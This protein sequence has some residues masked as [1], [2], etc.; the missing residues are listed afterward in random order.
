MRAHIDLYLTQVK[1]ALASMF[2]YRISNLLWLV[3]MVV[4]PVVYLVV[5][6]SV[7]RQ[8][9]GSVAGYTPGGFAAYYITW[10]LVRQMNIALTPY[11]FESRVRKGELSPMLLRPMHPF[12]FDLAWFMGFK[13]VTFVLWL[14]IA[15]VLTLAF[16]PTLDPTWWQVAAFLVVL[17]TGFVMRFV[18]LW[19]LGLVTFWVT[20]VS[21][22]FE[23]Y[24]TVELLLSGRLVPLDL[25]PPWARSLAD[26]LPFQWTFGYPIE[27]L[28]GRL[29]V[30]QTLWGM[31]MQAVWFAIGAAMIALL[32]RPAVRKYSAV[33]A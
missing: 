1:T 31:L 3:A 7:A 14:P 9:G 29:S 5:W 12:H 32:W 11:A 21:A 2:Q 4:E 30:A 16:R 20:R 19:V 23:L 15:L 27:V 18:L 28:L 22:V 24:F 33:G 25:L 17:V 10:T 8:Q 13:V 26:W 6:S